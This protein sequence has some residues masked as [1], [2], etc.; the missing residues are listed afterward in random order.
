MAFG[1]LKKKKKES[2]LILTHSLHKPLPQ[3]KNFLKRVKESFL[4]ELVKRYGTD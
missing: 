1:K 2:G 4:W 3:N